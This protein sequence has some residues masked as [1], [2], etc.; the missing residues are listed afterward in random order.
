M[1]TDAT[2]Y[3]PHIQLAQVSDHVVHASNISLGGLGVDTPAT[4]QAN[5]NLCDYFQVAIDPLGACVVAYTDDHNDYDGHTFVARQLSGPSLYA[6]A[7]GGSGV[8][9]SQGPIPLPTPDPSEPQVTDFLRDATGGSTLQPIPND[10]PY[11]ILSIRYGCAAQGALVQ[12]E[13]KMQVSALSPAPPNTYW[14][15]L[16]SAN[17]PG[18]VADRGD[19][20]YVQAATNGAGIPAFTFGSASRDSNGGYSYTSLGNAT[21]GELDTANNTVIVRLSTSALDPYVQHG[22]GVRPGSVLVG[23]RGET[24]AA[25]GSSV[26]HDETRGGTSYVVCGDLLDAQVAAADADFG[27]TPPTPNPSRSFVS[28]NL[29][30]PRAGWVDLALFDSQGRRVRTI[31]GGVLGAGST[32][33]HWDGRTDGGRAAPSGAYY[34]R[35]AVGGRMRTQRLVLVH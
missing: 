31:F 29:Q 10:N 35:M 32:G 22:P 27:I 23:L 6:S 3:N 5:R 4:P 2:A 26:G 1:T 12:L 8:L 17:A 25:S 20:F 18:P 7:N 28:F 24:G 13:T 19:Y 34:L 15:S 33:M 30:M 14:R 21:S 16:F 9:E 11:D